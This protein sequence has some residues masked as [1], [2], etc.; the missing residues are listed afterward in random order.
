MT[1]FL[2]EKVETYYARIYI[3]GDL[4][5]AKQVCREECA[6][7]GLCVTV[8]PSSYIYTG[9]EESGIIVGLINYPRFPAQR[10]AVYKRAQQLG[11]CLLRR[12]CQRSFTIETPT[13][14]IRYSVE[15]LG[16]SS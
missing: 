6:K 14:T 15:T 12:L 3:A 4:D 16:M 10:T 2:I 11:H 9:G 13:E 7:E 8:S 1:E 5:Q